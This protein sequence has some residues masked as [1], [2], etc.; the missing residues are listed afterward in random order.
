MTLFATNPLTP[1]TGDGQTAYSVRALATA[2]Q[3]ISIVVTGS[4][5]AAPDIVHYHPESDPVTEALAC[6]AVRHAYPDLPSV[7]RLMSD[8]A[9]EYHQR[10][11]AVA[12]ERRLPG[13]VDLDRMRQHEY[14]AL[15]FRA[16][17]LDIVALQSPRDI[18]SAAQ[19]A[20]AANN[21]RRLDGIGVAE[22]ETARTWLRVTY[23]AWLTEGPHPWDCAGGCG[24]QG[25]V[26]TYIHEDGV[27]VH[28]E[29][30]A[31]DRGNPALPHPQDCAACG[32]TGFTDD[33]GWSQSC[34]GYV[35]I[36]ADVVGAPDDDP[37]A[38]P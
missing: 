36:E 34:L 32:G 31:C 12:A 19:C 15:L 28:Q 18:H 10:E 4:T 16:V 37:W 17:A 38:R 8:Y 2:R 27:A 23:R 25:Y 30:D 5:D 29:P 1:D 7:G 35:E 13:T 3:P 26:M 24:G 33:D 22:Q 14:T 21:M 6:A 9:I 20:A 11:Q